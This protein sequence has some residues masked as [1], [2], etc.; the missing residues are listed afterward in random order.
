MPARNQPCSNEHASTSE[1]PEYEFLLRVSWRYDVIACKMNVIFIW[2]AKLHNVRMWNRDEK[3][4]LNFC[5]VRWTMLQVT[6]DSVNR[7]EYSRVA[8]GMK[9]YRIRVFTRCRI[10][11]NPAGVPYSFRTVFK[12]FSCRYRVDAR[13]IRY[14]FIPGLKSF[15]CSCDQLHSYTSCVC[16]NL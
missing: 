3:R 14:S 7:V 12:W 9:S 11:I 15:W 1:S 13:P 4:I 10:Q 5:K 6:R 8:S 2:I 16:I